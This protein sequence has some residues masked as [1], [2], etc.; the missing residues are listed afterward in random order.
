ME[1]NNSQNNNKIKQIKI[2]KPIKIKIN[3]DY[4]N[5]HIESRRK[6]DEN[7]DENDYSSE[8]S[9]FNNK[10]KE[11]IKNQE[12][13]KNAIKKTNNKANNINNN[14]NI[15]NNINNIQLNFPKSLEKENDN[16]GTHINYEE[17][18]KENKDEI[19]KS[20]DVIIEEITIPKKMGRN[21]HFFAFL[22]KNNR[23]ESFGPILYVNPVARRAYNPGDGE[24]Q[25]DYD[26]KN[27]KDKRCC[28]NCNICYC[29][30]PK[31]QFFNCCLSENLF[32]CFEVFL[33]YIFC[34]IS[35]IMFCIVIF[36]RFAYFI[37]RR[38]R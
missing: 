32:C 26:Y 19:I 37:W 4:N 15:I 38:G 14:I 1:S 12:L 34:F 22:N 21:K 23:R 3:H 7:R 17:K 20:N 29:H 16:I 2:N 31:Y 18:K 27:A 36:G 33:S 24:S 5:N 13:L 6:L 35:Y 8:N 9:Y 28:S 25:N 10:K 11:T 30:L